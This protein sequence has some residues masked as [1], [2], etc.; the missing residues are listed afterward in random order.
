VPNK[1]LPVPDG[2]VGDRLDNGLAKMLGISRTK[3]QELILA[4]QV[5]QNSVLCSKSERMLESAVIEVELNEGPEPLEVRPEDVPELKIVFQDEHL[6]VIDKPAGVVSHPSLGFEARAF[7]ECC[8]PGGFSLQPLVRR[9]A[10]VSF[11]G[12]ML[13]PA[14]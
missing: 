3:A 14:D 9:S 4:G 10:R 13:E 7:P 1:F 12:W 8:Y 6:I 5:W 2:L 11:S